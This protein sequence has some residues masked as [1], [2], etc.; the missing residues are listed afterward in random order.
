VIFL[1][2]NLLAAL[3][4]SSFWSQACYGA[5]LIVA[6]MFAARQRTARK[7]LHPRSQRSAREGTMT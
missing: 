5:V 2:E 6:I 1:I 3:N 7:G 4:I